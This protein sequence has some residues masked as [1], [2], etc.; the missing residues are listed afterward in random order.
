[1]IAKKIIIGFTND[2]AINKINSYCFIS[3]AIAA[4]VMPPKRARNRA[5]GGRL[6]MFFM[7]FSNFCLTKSV[8]SSEK[9]TASTISCS[10]ASCIFHSFF[11]FSF[12]KLFT[13]LVII[14]YNK[15]IKCQLKLILLQIITLEKS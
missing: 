5:T 11:A 9:P 1:M 14:A 2:A 13:K 12:L 8:S 6:S 4:L 10:L 15:N 7:V 3:I